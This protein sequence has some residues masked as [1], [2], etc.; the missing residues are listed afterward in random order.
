MTVCLA[1]LDI[2]K[3]HIDVACHRGKSTK[4]KRFDNRASG[5]RQLVKWLSRGSASVRV[6]LEATGIY[7][8]DLALCLAAAPGVEVMVLNPRQLRHFGAATQRRAKTDPLDAQL[9][10]EFLRHMPF[11]A[12]QPPRAIQLDLRAISRRIDALVQFHAA[13]LCRLEALKGT[14]V[15]PAVVRA[16]VELLLEQIDQHIQALRAAAHALIDQ[17]P[18]LARQRELVESVPGIARV[19]SIT[20]LAELGTLPDHLEVRQWVAMAGLDPQIRESGGRTLARPH[21]SKRGN[22][23]LRRVLFM[24]ALV[25]IRR[26]PHVRS[27]YQGLVQKGKPRRVAQVAVMRKVLHALYG[28]LKNDELFDP[29]KLFPRLKMA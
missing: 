4:H 7:Y 3:A 5:H 11:V 1:G 29:N 6:V 17:D 8:L 25:A 24:P 9:A 21:I 2:C 26:Q 28:M 20:L 14:H 18:Q 22:A 23:R 16:D 12:W 19:C 13:D 10:L 15:S 27:F